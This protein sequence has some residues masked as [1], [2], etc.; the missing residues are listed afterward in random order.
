MRRLLAILASLC[1]AT[2]ALIASA[3]PASAQS[4]TWYQVNWVLN[5]H[6]STQFLADTCYNNHFASY[7][8]PNGGGSP[9]L[10]SEI[11]APAEC[12][13]GGVAIAT[14]NNAG[15]P[16]KITFKGVNNS[17]MCEFDQW[18]WHSSQAFRAG[19][20]NGWNYRLEGSAWTPLWN[21]WYGG[22]HHNQT[23][24]TPQPTAQLAFYGI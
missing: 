18:G 15:T 23:L 2:I 4:C 8:Y 6:G 19:S 21:V 1:L 11:W 13:Q 7:D 24:C 14:G 17:T 20:C 3:S 5:A 22:V 9:Q 10:S 12:I 16:A